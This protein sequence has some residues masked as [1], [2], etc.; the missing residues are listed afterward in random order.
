MEQM[1]QHFCKIIDTSLICNFMA[2]RA[3]HAPRHLPRGRI[4]QACR[5]LRRFP[6]AK[7]LSMELLDM[8]G[9]FLPPHGRLLRRFLS[10][11]DGLNAKFFTK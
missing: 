4:S 8:E 2:R 7:F 3:K 9:Q 5:K 6:T 1:L 10:I 11:A